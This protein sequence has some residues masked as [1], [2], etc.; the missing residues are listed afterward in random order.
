M[1]GDYAV[2]ELG[3]S[4]SRKEPFDSHTVR[5]VEE[6]LS[7]LTTYIEEHHKD[8]ACLKSAMNTTNVKVDVISKLVNHL[9]KLSLASDK[10]ED[11]KVHKL[12]SAINLELSEIKAIQD[13][14]C[15][16]IENLEHKTTEEKSRQCHKASY[17]SIVKENH[18][19]LP[20]G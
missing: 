13:N 6:V 3:A 12:M 16:R 4:L 7:P 15:L 8:L 19:G 10:T 11:I 2:E 18:A 9:I 1:A 14:L 17:A 20:T 5:K